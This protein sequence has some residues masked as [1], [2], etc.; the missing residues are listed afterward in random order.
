MSNTSPP[1]PPPVSVQSTA[2]PMSVVRIIRKGIAFLFFIA[3][4]VVL[5]FA[6][7]IYLPES[8]YSHLDEDE[9]KRRESNEAVIEIGS[10]AV[11]A[12]TSIGL[13]IYPWLRKKPKP[14]TQLGR[15]PSY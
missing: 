2:P 6:T 10:K 4:L 15:K 1:P 14:T 8:K 7:L 12:L 13:I 11:G 9:S 3:A 5:V